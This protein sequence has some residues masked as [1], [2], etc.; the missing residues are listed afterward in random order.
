VSKRTIQLLVDDLDGGQAD[1]TVTFALDGV[2]YTIDLN[3][4]N[5]ARLRTLLGRYVTAGTRVGRMAA[6]SRGGEAGTRG[7]GSRRGA[8]QVDR[9]QSR[10]I[11]DW[12][13]SKGIDVAARGRI[14]RDVVERY[15]AEAGR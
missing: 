6:G 12:A 14:S 7:R 13:Q 1:E 8:A 10:A 4:K 5:A 3:R 15:Q 9:D 11:R 2:T